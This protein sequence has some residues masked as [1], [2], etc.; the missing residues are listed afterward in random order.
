MSEPLLPCPFCGRETAKPKSSGRWGWFVGCTCHAVGPNA[1]SKEDAIKAW[2]TRTEP[3]QGR[4]D[5]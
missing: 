5:I 2:N 3:L 4:L 1:E